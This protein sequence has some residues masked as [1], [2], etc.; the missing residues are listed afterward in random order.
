M[1][2]QRAPSCMMIAPRQCLTLECQR[3]LGSLVQLVGI[4]HHVIS[5]S[6]LNATQ[7]ALQIPTTSPR[8]IATSHLPIDIVYSS[9]GFA[10]LIETNACVPYGSPSGGRTYAPYGIFTIWY[11]QSGQV[12]SLS[13][14]NQLCGIFKHSRGIV[15]L[16]WRL[17]RAAQFNLGFV[18]V[19]P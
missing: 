4:D 2:R 6:E 14:A 16:Q 7:S 18:A 1:T 11:P 8:M 15:L 10:A 12:I 19:F 9:D 3:W 13:G 17:R 5:F